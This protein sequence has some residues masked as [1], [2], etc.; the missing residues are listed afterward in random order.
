MSV[1]SKLP[2][3]GRLTFFYGWRIIALG[4]LLNL[5]T[6]GLSSSAFSVFVSPMGNDLGGRGLRL[7]WQRLLEPWRPPYPGTFWDKRWTRGKEPAS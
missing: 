2:L 7:Y 4:F 3:A 6:A 1:A 5:M